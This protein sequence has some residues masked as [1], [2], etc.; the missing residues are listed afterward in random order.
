MFPFWSYQVP[1][2]W[3]VWFLPSFSTSSISISRSLY[4]PSFS[5]SLAEILLSDG[6]HIYELR[7]YVLFIFDYYI[8]SVSLYC[9]VS[10]N[11]EITENGHLWGIHKKQRFVLIPLVGCFNSIMVTHFPVYILSN[12]IVSVCILI[13]GKN[14]APWD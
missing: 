3:L 2:Q 9:S 12:T 10:S 6:T 11:G 8:W 5:N 14:S 1:L 13:W 4:L 7:H